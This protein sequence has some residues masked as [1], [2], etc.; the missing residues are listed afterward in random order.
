MKIK[1]YIIRNIIY[2]ILILAAFLRIYNLSTIPPHLTSDEAA[3]GYNAYS[4]LRT[5]KDEYGEVLPI[6]FKSFG[7]YKPGFYVYLTVPF[8]ATLGLNELAVRL[9]SALSGVIAVWLIFLIAKKLFKEKD[10]K[11]IAT[12]AAFFLAI[13][14]WHIHFSRGAW[15]INLSLTLTLAGIYFLLRSFEKSKFIML[16]S[17]FF[18]LTLITYQGAKLSTLIVLVV[19][20]VFYKDKI[21][22][23][24]RKQKLNIAISVILGIIIISP[25]IFSFT[26]G[27]TGR[28]AI[29][30][31][32]S[33]P[34]KSYDI[35]NFLDQ[36]NEL[37]GGLSYYLHHSESLNF[38]RVI[39]EKWFNHFSGRFLFFEGDWPNPRHSA[40][41]MGML[42]ISDLLF[43]IIGMFSL[44][45]YKRR[46]ALLI[47]FWLVLAPLP[48]VLTRDQVHAVRAYNMVIPL[49]LISSLGFLRVLEFIGDRKKSIVRTGY[50][51][52]LLLVVFASLI[53]YFEAYY[54]HLPKHSS[55]LW[56]YGYKQIVETVTPVQQNYEKVKIQQS[57]AQP[58]IY[59]LFYQKYD[60]VKYQEQA[61][62]TDINFRGDVGYVEKLDNIYFW[63]INWP[64]DKKE[65]HTLVIADEIRIP[66]E[67]FSSEEN[68]TLIEEINY[69]DGNR[70]F[71]VVEVD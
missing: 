43:L 13:S 68:L 34:R 24:L 71:R 66:E 22:N 8:V 32:F 9:P 62:L 59:F 18:S 45:K 38:G 1:K 36:G 39:M 11:L 49:V 48:S 35:N 26:R 12:I 23:L 47:L 16:S 52:G 50:C 53:Y 15:E 28:L 14:P 33:Y 3:L 51:L 67:D 65:P 60:P 44:L 54:V 63:P 31:V 30:S 20:V 61:V 41:N 64:D 69:L 55:K 10:K 56:S 25:S 29:F 27:E 58:Y 17:V 46:V 57:F 2:L 37:V 19:M 4:I 7:D 42:L 6:I 21:F 5:G 40:P 70:A